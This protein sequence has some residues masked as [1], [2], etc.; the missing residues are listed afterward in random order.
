MKNPERTL[1]SPPF[2]RLSEYEAWATQNWLYPSGTDGA[3]LHARAKLDEETI[4]L[5]EAL[6][7]GTPEDIISEAGDVLWTTHA[8]GSN[9]GLSISQALVESYPAIFHTDQITTQSIDELGYKMF[10]GTSLEQTQRYLAQYGST[11]GKNAKQWFRLSNT[12][13][14]VPETFGDAWIGT[15]RT[16]AASALADIVL[17]TSFSLQEFADAHLQVAM[18][19]NYRKIEQRIKI[20]AALTKAPRS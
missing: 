16:K 17:L 20:G 4:E 7:T 19:T 6:T 10:E 8:S 9:S 18:D 14:P 13:H 5:A 11:I 15:K 3:Q 2:A 1:S 12:V